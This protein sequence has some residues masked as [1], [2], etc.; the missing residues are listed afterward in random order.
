MNWWQAEL[1]TLSQKGGNTVTKTKTY[2]I[3]NR[4]MESETVLNN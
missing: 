4:N 3:V 1:A 2:I